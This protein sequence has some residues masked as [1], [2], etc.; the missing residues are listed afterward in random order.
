MSATVAFRSVDPAVGAAGSFLFLE[1]VD[2]C[3][4]R[5]AVFLPALCTA[6]LPSNHGDRIEDDFFCDGVDVGSRVGVDFCTGC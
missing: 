1:T 4:S 5:L 2:F 3:T 6:K